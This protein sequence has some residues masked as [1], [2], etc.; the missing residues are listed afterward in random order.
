METTEA[1]KLLH[2]IV[3]VGIYL[4]VGGAVPASAQ[5]DVD[6]AGDDTV[7]ATDAELGMLLTPRAFRAAAA[8][9]RPSLVV[10]ESFGG[11]STEQGKIGGI[12]KQGEGNTTGVVISPDG[13]VVTS[14]FNFIRQ[15]PV[16]TVVTSDGKQ[17]VAKLLGRDETRKLC[18]LKIDN[19]EGLPVPEIASIDELK[20]G[21]WS[22]SVGVGYGDVN[23]AISMGII[24]ALNRVGGKAIQTDANVS[25]AN[26]GGPLID[27]DG[28]LLGI[29]VPLNPNS[30]AIG[31]GVE[32]YDSGIGFAIPLDN[33][34]SL[35][36]RLKSGEVISPAF[37][38]VVVTPNPTGRG[39]RVENV[40]SEGPADTGGIKNGDVIRKIG[41]HIVDDVMSLRVAINR[42]TA[43]QEAIVE[44]RRRV[45][46]Q[47]KKKS[48]QQRAD[49]DLPDAGDKRDGEPDQ[50]EEPGAQD[51]GPKDKGGGPGAKSE[52]QSSRIK[53][54]KLSVTFGKPPA[55]KDAP[56]VPDFNNQ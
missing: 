10:I 35:L 36:D 41:P 44:I 21:Q 4:L 15:P 14:T 12:R 47:D 34:E 43:G 50:Q 29:C 6:D 40:V 42:F 51:D 46:P 19:V 22:I 18:L 17:R 54:M 30:N 5:V 9:I 28:R 3:A 31:A 24:S 37:L 20:V 25:P 53:T 39:V 49:D 33:Q 11:V 48:E 7:Q 8:K 52:A 1:M 26:Y 45:K 23:E 32:W 55:P 38:G 13:Y 2:I 16:I 56:K 27:L